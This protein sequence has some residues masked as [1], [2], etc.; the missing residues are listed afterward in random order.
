MQRG[1]ICAAG[2]VEVTGWK[3]IKIQCRKY[4][5]LCS[6]M[7]ITEGFQQGRFEEKQRKFDKDY[8]DK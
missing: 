7:Q 3:V 1:S 8:M 5:R 6:K 2:L 4:Q